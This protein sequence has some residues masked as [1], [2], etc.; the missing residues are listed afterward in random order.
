M[1]TGILWTAFLAAVVFPGFALAQ[2]GSFVFTG[3]LVTPVAGQTATLLNNGQ[4]LIV[5]GSTNCTGSGCSCPAMAE[6]YDPANG[7]FTNT[8]A[9]N[10]PRSALMALLLMTVRF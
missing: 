2:Q 3:S 9:L 6:L 7:T 5:G 8:G 4:V 10:V 1:V